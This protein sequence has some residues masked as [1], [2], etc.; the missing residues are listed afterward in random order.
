MPFILESIVLLRK[1]IQKNIMCELKEA[2]LFEIRPDHKILAS[3]WPWHIKV[4]T[5]MGRL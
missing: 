3:I 1:S 2:E 4:T 5:P